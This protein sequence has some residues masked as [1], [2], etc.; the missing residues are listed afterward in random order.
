[1][2]EEVVVE[3]GRRWRRRSRKRRSRKRRSRKR[4]S[5]KRKRSRRRKWW[6]R[7]RRR[8]EEKGG[9]RREE[10]GGRREEGE[11]R[12]G[13]RKKYTR[14]M[15]IIKLTKSYSLCTHICHYQFFLNHKNVTQ[16]TTVCGRI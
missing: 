16:T 15:Q 5:R 7:R 12:G 3:R 8:R 1:M 11:G 4:R 14:A 2:E 9:V 13:T 10:G 6:W